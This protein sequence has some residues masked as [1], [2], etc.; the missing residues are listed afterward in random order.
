MTVDLGD[1]V[2]DAINVY[3]GQDPLILAQE[4]CQK[5]GL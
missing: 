3:I 2:S 1:G 4:F 5:H